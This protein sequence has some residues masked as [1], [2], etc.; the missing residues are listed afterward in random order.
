MLLGL[1]SKSRARIVNHSQRNFSLGS[2]AASAHLKED[3]YFL[4]GVSRSEDKIR[5]I[6]K[7]YFHKAKQ[8]H[9]DL[10]PG[11]EMAK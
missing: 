4:L 1:L 3:P 11:D 9:P 7:A 10:N 8:Y 6:K 2:D 5:E